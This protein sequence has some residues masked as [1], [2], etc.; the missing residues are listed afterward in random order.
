MKIELTNNNISKSALHISVK[1]N[2]K[3]V[4]ILYLTDDE[5]ND[6]I[7]ALKF[8]TINTEGVEFENN[9]FTDDEDDFEEE[10]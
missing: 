10:R 7:R 4:G 6:F 9:C 8:G 3:D 2:D 5:L 1:I